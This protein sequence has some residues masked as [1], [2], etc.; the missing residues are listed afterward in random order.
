M[1]EWDDRELDAVGLGRGSE[2]GD[3]RTGAPSEAGS[4]D[5]VAELAAL[6]AYISQ[7]QDEGDA[8]AVAT[9][10]EAATPDAQATAAQVGLS[11]ANC[12]PVYLSFATFMKHGSGEKCIMR[13]RFRIRKNLFAQQIIYGHNLSG[14]WSK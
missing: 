1:P 5:S 13:L 14:F 8:E 9:S 3:G 7:Q 2:A 10:W 11:V 12:I 4:R 6:G